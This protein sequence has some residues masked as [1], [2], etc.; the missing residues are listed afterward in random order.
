M[1]KKKEFQ[2]QDQL[3]N[4]KMEKVVGGTSSSKISITI[5]MAPTSLLSETSSGKD[6]DSD[7]DDETVK[8]PEP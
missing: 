7:A 5:S 2:V 1:E 6:K 8:Q 4:E 3:A